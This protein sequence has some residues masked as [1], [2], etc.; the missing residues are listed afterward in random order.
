MAEVT[1]KALETT[2]PKYDD[3]GVWQRFLLE[4]FLG[5]GGFQGRVKQPPAG[6]WGHAA[7]SYSN[8][9]LLGLLGTSVANEEK[10]SYL[11]RHVREDA[12]KFQRR[13]QVA[14]YLNY[15]RPTTELKISYLVRKPLIRNNVPD[16]LQEWIKRTG[17]DQTFRRRA[18]VAFVLGWLH[19]RVDKPKRTPGALTAAQ[20]GNADPFIVLELPCN[21]LDYEVDESN[22]LVWAKYGTTFTR[23]P[24]FDAP[25]TKVTRYTI[26][27][28]TEFL[29]YETEEVNGRKGEPKLI[30]SG[31][32]FAANKGQDGCVPTVSWRAS[33]SIED[34]IKAESLTGDVSVEARRLF[35]LYSEFDEHIRGQVFAVL[36]YP[37]A[38]VP[39]EDGKSAEVGVENGLIIDPDQKNVPS[40]IAPPADIAKTFETRIERSVIEIYRMARVEYD[41]ASG[42][43]SSAQSKEQNFEQTN[44][45]IADFAA[46]MAQADRE[47]LYMVGL[48]LGISESE[49]DKM[50]VEAHASYATEELNDEIDAI[51]QTL[52]LSM[53]LTYKV[54]L[55]RRLAAR[56]L[57]N[58]SADARQKIETEIE[59][60]AKQAEQ[61]AAA[62]K[63]AAED[64]GQ[65]P[66]GEEP[67]PADDNDEGQ[68]SNA[69]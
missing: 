35:N 59:E 50:T 22:Q 56:M 61:E 54:E 55:L 62:L 69:A 6:F 40:F 7:E 68:R 2:R 38:S 36:I 17:Y 30:D 3:E 10:S 43:R 37:R 64:D 16:A 13:V 18:L 52:T 34:P 33:T 29:V 51:T 41:R 11:D 57:P 46:A 8:F 58:L 49:L 32:H 12:D 27:T 24:T 15:V 60:A 4:A 19:V 14:H 45:A 44:L 48:A 1:Q 23:R 25:C 39:A 47:T 42:T 20:A 67:P 9:S 63:K 53:G 5:C 65:D 26:W 66:D 21:V 31:T 28:R